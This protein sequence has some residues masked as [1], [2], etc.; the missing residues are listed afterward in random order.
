MLSLT[1][2][3]TCAMIACLLFPASSVYGHG[4]GID[5]ISSIDIQGKEI[6]ISV[7]MPMYFEN[8]Q[9]QITITSTEDETKE[10]AKNVTFLIGLFYDNE[11]NFRNY[12]FAENGVLPIKISPKDGFDNFMIHGEQDSILGAYHGTEDNPIEITGP[13]F[14]SGGLYTFEIEVRTIDEPTNIIVD[15]GVYTADLSNVDTVSY[16]YKDAENNEL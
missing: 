9:E 14:T 15:S 2:F 12:F 16:I 1:K 7:E 13:I 3:V 4:L 10:N 11:M 5:T 8:N 6:S